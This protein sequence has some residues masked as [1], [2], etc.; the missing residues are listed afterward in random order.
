MPSTTG[1][2]VLPKLSRVVFGGEEPKMP[3]DD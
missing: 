2:I 1:E 3:E